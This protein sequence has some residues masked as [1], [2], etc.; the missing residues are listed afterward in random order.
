MD[1][2][3][4]STLTQ[5]K[6]IFIG[7]LGVSVLALLVAAV[8]RDNADLV[9]W[10]VWLRGGAVALASLWLISLAGQAL[11]GKRPAFVRIRF[12]SILAPLGIAAILLAPDS[13]YPLWMK[14][15][16]GLVG[17]LLVGVAILVNRPAVRAAFP[18]A[19]K[20]G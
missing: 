2:N 19:G 10:V 4:V 8:L 16:Q 18:K 9:N 15:E 14:A 3:V 11:R 1:N 5:I 17:L 6:R 12:I 7:M 13:G 20:M